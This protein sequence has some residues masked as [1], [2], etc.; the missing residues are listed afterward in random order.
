VLLLLRTR[1]DSSA[2]PGKGCCCWLRRLLAGMHQPA[3]SS[4]TQVSRIRTVACARA[5]LD[6]PST[7]H[8]CCDCCSC[9][10]CIPPLP[11]HA[12]H[13]LQ[14]LHLPRQELHLAHQLLH[15]VPPAAAA[16]QVRPSQHGLL[17]GVHGCAWLRAQC[18]PAPHAQ[19]KP[20]L[21]GGIGAG[22]AAAGLQQPIPAAAQHSMTR[23][24]T[25]PTLPVSAWIA[26]RCGWGAKRHYMHTPGRL[27]E[28][29]K[30]VLSCSTGSGA[31]CRRG[32]TMPLL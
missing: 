8:C 26:V 16:T 24:P 10:V 12:S 25:N 18:C 13:L 6:V 32:L 30:A 22:V 1:P 23:T 11:R 19:V 14:R 15:V 5:W 29:R 4:R 27:A 3:G 9:H 21:Q 31:S 28:L 20:C 7:R 2:S 17:H